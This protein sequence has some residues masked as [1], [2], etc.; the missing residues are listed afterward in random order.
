M[1]LLPLLS[2]VSGITATVQRA[3]HGAYQFT[4]MVRTLWCH[5]QYPQG[6]APLETESCPCLWQEDRAGGSSGHVWQE[7]LLPLPTISLR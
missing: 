5:Q 4:E 1:R 6:P 3:Q 2:P 7:E